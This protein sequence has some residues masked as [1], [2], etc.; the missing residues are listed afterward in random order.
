M[1]VFLEEFLQ[2]IPKQTQLQM[3]AHSLQMAAFEGNLWPYPQ[4]AQDSLV[5]RGWGKGRW[6]VGYSQ[7]TKLGSGDQFTLK[8]LKLE[9]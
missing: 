3:L 9:S 6:R 5:N 8:I 2:K 7:F 4:E 1:I